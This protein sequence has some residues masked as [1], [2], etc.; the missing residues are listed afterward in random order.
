MLLAF[1]TATP[2]ISVAVHDDNCVLGQIGQV[3]D[4]RRHGE[5]LAPTISELLAELRLTPG[6]LSAIAVG[7][8]PGP[9]TGLRVGL[10]SAQTMGLALD[11]PV[12]GVGTLDALALQAQLAGAIREGDDFLVATD[13]RRAE[14]YWSQFTAAVPLPIRRSDPAVAIASSIV[15]EQLPVVGRG[16]QLYPAALG[17]SVGPLD[18]EAS[19]VAQWA[20]RA[21]AD[22][23]DLADISPQYLRRPDI[24]PGAPRKSVLG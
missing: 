15:R 12:Y 10:V 1:D 20:I 13:A 2:L 23:R 24:H 16:A 17:E 9:F 22:G 7:V 11:I 3:I 8:G 6:D 14:V 4:A 21:L 19:A 18:L 5:L